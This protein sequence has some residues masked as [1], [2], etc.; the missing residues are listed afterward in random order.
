MLGTKQR[1]SGRAGNNLNQ[2]IISIEISIGL[3]KGG[4]SGLL[5][6]SEV[7]RCVL[8]SGANHCCS[9]WVRKNSVGL[10]TYT[11]VCADPTEQHT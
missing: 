5:Y 2:K 10:G 3:V 7:K 4:S 6:H 11:S 1:S 8:G 9:D